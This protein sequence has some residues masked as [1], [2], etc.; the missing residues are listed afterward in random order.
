MGEEEESVWCTIE[1]CCSM[2]D[3]SCESKAGIA[4]LSPCAGT[5][6]P[7]IREA[8]AKR[9]GGVVEWEEWEVG[10]GGGGGESDEVRRRWRCASPLAR[11]Q[12]VGVQQILQRRGLLQSGRSG[13]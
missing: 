8:V 10:G 9:S 1:L 4:A 2:I 13:S 5:E 11:D 3:G 6:C 7:S 12:C